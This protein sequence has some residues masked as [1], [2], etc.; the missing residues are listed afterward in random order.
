MAYRGPW[1]T[2]IHIPKCGGVALRKY[3]KM[4]YSDNGDEIGGLH[5]ILPNVDGLENP[6]TVVR[7]PA[8][9]LLSYFTYCEDNAWIWRDRP[10][11][12]G[13][14]FRFADGMFWPSFV[15]EV[16]T[17]NPGAVGKVFDLYCVPGVEVY[18]LE[19]INTVMGEH[20]PVIHTQDI[21]PVMTDA[22]WEMI[23]EAE[24]GTLEKYGY[25]NQR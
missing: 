1:G 13:D 3:L 20:V 23:C 18:R 9:W 6:W 10:T 7:H 16:C 22:H 12:V 5:E 11:L 25:D 2:F 8:H 24:M 4:R 19:D 21:K 14:Q 17:V 15:A